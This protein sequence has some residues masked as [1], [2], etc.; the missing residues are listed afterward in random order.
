VWDKA[1]LSFRSL[2]EACRVMTAMDPVRVISNCIAA[3]KRE[4][5]LVVFFF[6]PPAWATRR[7]SDEDF[8]EIFYHLTDAYPEEVDEDPDPIFLLANLSLTPNTTMSASHVVKTLMKIMETEDNEIR[9]ALL[10]PLFSRIENRDIQHAL[11]RLSVKGSVVKR[12]HIL[13]ALARVN[14]ELMYRVRRASF[15]VG[16]ERVCSVLSEGQELW[17]LITPKPSI[18]LVIPA[19]ISMETASV[20][21]TSC[22]MEYP[23]GEW[24]TLHVLKDGKR[25]LFDSAGDEVVIEDSTIAMTEDFD[26]GVY[27]VEYASGREIE[28]MVVDILFDGSVDFSYSRRRD[29]MKE[30]LPK[31][32]IKEVIP[33]DDPTE[34]V[35]HIEEKASVLLW[36]KDGMLTYENTRYEVVILTLKSS[37]SKV[38][39]VMGGKWV[40]TVEGAPRLGKWRVAAR[41]GD[42]FY[43][44]GLIEAEVDVETRL[45][46]VCPPSKPYIGDE[47]ALTG[48][49]FVQ[50]DVYAAGWGDYGPYIHGRIISISPE[51]GL[52]DCVG[53][54]EIEMLCGDQE[55]EY[56]G[57]DL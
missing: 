30:R 1:D 20:P 18:G 24:M 12:R 53:V 47:M 3:M 27:L 13:A 4:Q 36:N 54:E 11:M 34:A 23:E 22:Y 10:R 32:A 21:F 16:L 33:L 25:M 26:N 2:G 51:S 5:W 15:L 57:D 48:P 45:K 37:P 7:L 46:K 52:S 28:I 50:V 38:F 31:W 43:P 49:M 29:S 39:R 8:R 41:D 35:Q 44:V 55:G 6:Y 17:P 56:D 40:E 42:S 19:P 14:S 9:A